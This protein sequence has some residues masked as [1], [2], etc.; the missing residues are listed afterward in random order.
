MAALLQN[1]GDFVAPQESKVSPPKM[2]KNN[3]KIESRFK[4]D[5]GADMASTINNRGVELNSD[6][7]NVSAR[8]LSG[9]QKFL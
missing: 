7:I 3:T 1:C 6:N 5:N 8:I 4:R 9:Q 2:I